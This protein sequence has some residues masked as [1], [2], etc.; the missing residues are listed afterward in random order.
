MYVC[1]YER[2]MFVNMYKCTI[3]FA[4]MYVRSIYILLICMYER[5]NAIVVSYNAETVY[6]RGF[7]VL[8]AG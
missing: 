6:V 2:R 5:M 4:R 1:M 3:C 7:R 8:L